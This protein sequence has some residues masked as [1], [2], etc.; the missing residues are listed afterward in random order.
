MTLSLDGWIFVIGF[1]ILLVAILASTRGT[2][3]SRHRVQRD[4]REMAITHQP[5]RRTF[6]REESELPGVNITHPDAE[7]HIAASRWAVEHKATPAWYEYR[8]NQQIEANRRNRA[9]G[10]EADDVIDGEVTEV[11]QLPAGR[12]AL[13]QGRSNKL[14]KG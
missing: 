4:S 1:V 7:K 2:S 8:I 5:K 13:P 10:T 3:G 12:R 11:K 6:T 9:L 14:L